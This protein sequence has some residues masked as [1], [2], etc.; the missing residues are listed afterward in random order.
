MTALPE[1]TSS[2]EWDTYDFGTMLYGIDGGTVVVATLKKPPTWREHSVLQCKI[3]HWATE[4]EDTNNFKLDGLNR[5][6]PQT[7]PN[8]THG[9]P[10]LIE[11][12]QSGALLVTE[13][14]FGK[15]RYYSKQR[16]LRQSKASLLLVI[17]WLLFT[18]QGNFNSFFRED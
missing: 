15:M 16:S 14:P 11:I 1:Q 6:Q 4:G 13:P 7:A 5:K 17:N 2:R 8:Y 3:S 18:C 10:G 12:R 9:F